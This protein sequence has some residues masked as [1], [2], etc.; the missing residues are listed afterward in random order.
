MTHKIQH[1]GGAVMND[2]NELKPGLGSRLVNE[3]NVRLSTIGSRLAAQAGTKGS[4]G[5]AKQTSGTGLDLNNTRLTG[6]ATPTQGS[7]LINLTYFRSFED[8][9]TFAQRFFDC[10]DLKAPRG[11]AGPSEWTFADVIASKL[12]VYPNSDFVLFGSFKRLGPSPVHNLGVIE[13]P[14]LATAPPIV[15]R[16]TYDPLT[17]G[18]SAR[19]FMVDEPRMVLYSG[20]GEPR[21]GGFGRF[22]TATVFNVID[23]SNVDALTLI[24]S[25]TVLYLDGPPGADGVTTG[26]IDGVQNYHGGQAI[27]FQGGV[28]SMITGAPANIRFYI[29]DVSSGAIVTGIHIFDPFSAGGGPIGGVAVGEG[30]IAYVIQDLGDDPGHGGTYQL[31][32]LDLTGGAIAPP[33]GRDSQ[34]IAT[35]V[36]GALNTVLRI[37]AS[38]TKLHI[39]HAQ[40]TDPEIGSV[41]VNFHWKIYDISTPGHPV[42]KHDMV[43]PCNKWTGMYVDGDCVMLTE[44][45]GVAF[46]ST[47]WDANDPSNPRLIGGCKQHEASGFELGHFLRN[48]RGY[49]LTGLGGRFVIQ[50]FVGH[51]INCP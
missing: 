46:N 22:R 39:L 32:S 3:L 34:T 5:I 47:L 48:S 41:A 14:P 24:G 12:Y 26:A 40:Y 13:M 36:P 37:Q 6:V 15:V 8:C 31:I 11:E 17:P 30:Q 19:G 42:L 23:I 50:D 4:V 2:L 20:A 35:E 29:A 33:I 49:Y 28:G 1:I 44:S 43:D 38:G 45:F 10:L 7:D 16:S 51:G 9:D 21:L 27:V 18:E 25:T